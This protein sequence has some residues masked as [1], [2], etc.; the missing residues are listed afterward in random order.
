M[1]IAQRLALLLL[2][3]LIGA[4]T[5]LNSGGIKNT[6]AVLASSGFK[7]RLAETPEQ[8][9]FM[10]SLPPYQL[11]MSEQDGSVVYLYAVPDK[12]FVYVGGPNEYALYQTTLTQQKISNNDRMAAEAQ[13]INNADYD[14]VDG[15]LNPWWYN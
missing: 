12:N 2:P 6:E 10:K 5:V 7:P 11:K 15:W 8:K 3:L 1:K 14:A 13:Y 4:C 9:A